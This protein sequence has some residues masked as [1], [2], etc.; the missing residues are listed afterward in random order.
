MSKNPIDLIREYRKA[1]KLARLAE[2]A[3]MSL[4]YF[5]D[6]MAGRHRLNAKAAAAVA[7]ELR[8]A[9]FIE[10]SDLAELHFQLACRNMPIGDADHHPTPAHS[11]RA[12]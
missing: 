10:D 3:D 6:A 5:T 2:A 1:H 4:R 8:A 7:K 9:G 12:S 11:A